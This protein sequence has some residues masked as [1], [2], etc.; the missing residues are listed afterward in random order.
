M[1]LK[2]SLNNLLTAISIASLGKL[3]AGEDDLT[4][5]IMSIDYATRTRSI[6]S[7]VQFEDTYQIDGNA[8]C[9]FYI[10]VEFKLAPSVLEAVASLNGDDYDL[11]LNTLSWSLQLPSP[12]YL[13]THK[14]TNSATN[15]LTMGKIYVEC[16]AEDEDQALEALSSV[17]SNNSN[18]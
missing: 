4:H 11:S 17:L 13:P 1:D 16:D 2:Q 3:V 18:A 6:V 10:V 12:K 9:E 8:E 5:L 15:W 7:S 14:H